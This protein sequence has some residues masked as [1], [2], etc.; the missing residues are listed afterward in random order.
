M[1]VL[2]PTPGTPEIPSRNARPEC[3]EQRVGL[4]AMVLARGL[5][6]RD[7]L[8]ERAPAQGRVGAEQ[9]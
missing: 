9:G 1:N 6:Q 5:D 7:R 8:R 2:L 4:R 3:G